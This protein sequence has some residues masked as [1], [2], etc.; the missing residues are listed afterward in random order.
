M[1]VALAVK[2][3]AIPDVLVRQGPAPGQR[4]LAGGRRAVP[5]GR[6]RV[7]VRR[8][9]GVPVVDRRGHRRRRPDR[10]RVRG[11]PARTHG[12]ASRTRRRSARRRSRSS[13]A[14][15]P[16]LKEVASRPPAA[17]GLSSLPDAALPVLG[18]LPVH[19]RA[20]REEPGGGRRATTSASRS[21][22]AAGS[23]AARS[24][25][26]W[27]RSGRTASPP[28]RLLMA[29][30]FALGDRDARVR[31][32]QVSLRRFAALLFVGFFTFFLGK[33]SADTIMQQ[34]MPDDF[35]GRAFALFDIAYNLGFIV[36]ALILSFV[37]IEER[38]HAHARD[39]GRVGRGVPRADGRDLPRGRAGSA[40]SSLRRTT[41]VDAQSDDTAPFE[42][43]RDL[44]FELREV[45]RD[46]ADV[47]RAAGSTPSAPVR[48]G[49]RSTPG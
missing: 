46:L 16:G 4:P 42:L 7:R 45:R 30:M 13:P 15:S 38:R 26:S 40:T 32:V 33:I 43:P 11:E 37:W 44:R 3:A 1:R 17:L 34:S 25:W 14:S 19:V 29:S 18:V 2:S 8:G 36:P 39:P 41:C 31:R 27:R 48:A 6:H 20:L 24:A 35:R 10:R 12:D 47:E 49:T 23:W 5:G 22:A 28:I 21:S 9:G